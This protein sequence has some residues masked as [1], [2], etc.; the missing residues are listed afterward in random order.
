MPGDMTL[1]GIDYAI[2]A[3][4]FVFVLGI[5]ATLK[6]FMRTSLDFFES[7]RSL[8]AWITALAF[9]P[10]NL[11]AQEV[12]GW[13]ASGAKHGHRHFH[14]HRVVRH[15]RGPRVCHV[16]LVL[17][18][19]LPPDSA[20]H[21]CAVDERRAANRKQNEPVPGASSLTPRKTACYA[22]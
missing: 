3:L 22:G 16:V 13:A 19:G 1:H 18:H 14:G 8:P 12:I 15:G 10:A 6:R 11:G 20:R 2:I 17:V 5:G 21:G 4:N 7:G 9:I